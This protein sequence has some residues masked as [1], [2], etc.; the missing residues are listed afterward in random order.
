L[1]DTAAG[2]SHEG[3]IATIVTFLREIGIDVQLTAFEHNSILPGVCLDQGTM[4]IN[5]SR[6]AN[7]GDLLHE[8]GHLALTPASERKNLHGNLGTDPGNEMGAIAWS[9]AAA[10]HI[11]LDPTILFHASG[12]HGWSDSIVEN[13]AA[14]RFI[15]VPMLEWRGLVA[16]PQERAAGAVPYPAVKQWLSD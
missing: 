3:L 15:G 4:L 9:Y 11:G 10:L 8:A 5:Q 12:Y 1:I 14:G 6:L 7:P 16:G 2:R 13:F